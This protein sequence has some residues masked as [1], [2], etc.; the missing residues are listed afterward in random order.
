MWIRDCYWSVCAL[1][2]PIINDLHGLTLDE[3]DLHDITRT[4][5]K[6]YDEFKLPSG[7]THRK[8]KS[9]SNRA[10]NESERALITTRALALWSTWT[11]IDVTTLRD[12]AERMAA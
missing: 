12:E 1:V 9:T 3:T 10:M 7:D 6:L 2:V 8:L 11:G 4:K 5:L